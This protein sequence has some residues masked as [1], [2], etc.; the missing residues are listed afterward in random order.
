MRNYQNKQ[1]W[2]DAAEIVDAWRVWP[3]IMMVLFW[4]FL[5]DVHG[6][7]TSIPTPA[8]M[9][10]YANLVFGSVSALTGFYIG[11]GRK[12]GQ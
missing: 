4:V 10:V 1:I 3:R 7:Y 12:W 6:W 11:T 2:L 9:Q 5:W 8:G